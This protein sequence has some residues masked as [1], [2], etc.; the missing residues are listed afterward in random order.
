MTGGEGF[1]VGYIFGIV[2]AGFALLA[3]ALHN[4][5][6]VKKRAPVWIGKDEELAKERLGA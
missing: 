3:Q 4:A 2:T 6:G 5:A 1:L